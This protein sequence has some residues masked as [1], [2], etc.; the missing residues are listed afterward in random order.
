MYINE[1][2]R[3]E[4]G[5]EIEGTVI[6]YKNDYLHVYKIVDRDFFTK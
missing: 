4:E 1:E 6:K 2:V 5:N 3:Q